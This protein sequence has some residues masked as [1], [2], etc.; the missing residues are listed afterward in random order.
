MS[1]K[2]NI[3]VIM[4]DQ[5]SA[6]MMSCAGNAWLRTPNIDRLAASGIRFERA[7]A[8]NPVCVPSRFSIQTGRM[9][10]AI[11]MKWNEELPVPDAIVQQSLGMLFDGAG[12][13]TVYSGKVHLPGVLSNPESHGY[14]V[15][16]R[17]A[18]QGLA[19]AC[20]KYLKR[21]HEKP[22]MLFAS[23]INPHD[24]C[25]MAINDALRALGKGPHDCIDSRTC[26]AVAD[27]VRETIAD[28]GD[29]I[30]PLPTNF[31]ISESEPQAISTEY[32]THEFLGVAYRRHARE[33]WGETEWRIFR[34]VY[35]RLTEMVDAKVGQVLDALREA[36]LEENTLVVF[37]SD[38]G[39]MDGAHKLQHKSVLYEEAARVPL[40]L[41]QR[42]TI[43]GRAVDDGHLVS[44]GLDLLPTLCDAA[45]IKCPDGLQGSS[46]LPLAEGDA[47]IIWR[48]HVLVES[49]HGRMLRTDRHKYCIYF[50][51]DNREQLFNLED[52]PGEMTNLADNRNVETILNRHRQHLRDWLVTTGDNAG[53]RHIEH[54]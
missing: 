45:K 7:Y 23:F 14:T 34:H 48:D 8:T 47:D 3:L 36:G 6:H 32:L 24:I 37:T 52:D 42:G 1:N 15:L 40:I 18:R 20:C 49:L 25:F 29:R 19:D 46:L 13:E 11:G 31:D 39:D 41:S 50:S 33:K 21:P 17:D 38:H 22:F 27:Q 53:L 10:S 51:G 43:P 26:E 44:N 2:P 30:T 35:R 16:T 9:P 28:A 12:Y 54:G 4:T 5:Q